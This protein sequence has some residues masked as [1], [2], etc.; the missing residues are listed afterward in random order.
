MIDFLKNNT[1]NDFGKPELMH[2]KQQLKQV[3]S[4]AIDMD[5]QA[6]S[7]SQYTPEMIH[8]TPLISA[9]ILAN[10]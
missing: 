10:H 5:G 7:V 3:I 9:V 1:L 4:I 8:H 6:H 2:N